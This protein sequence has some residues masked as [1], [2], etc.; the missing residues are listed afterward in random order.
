MIRMS[1]G[2]GGKVVAYGLLCPTDMLYL[3]GA[4][5]KI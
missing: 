4:E 5:L 3:A 1:Y 2:Q